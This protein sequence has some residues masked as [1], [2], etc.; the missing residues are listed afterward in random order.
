MDMKGEYRINASREAVWAGLND[1][2]VLRQSIP[3]CESL[4]KTSDTDFAAQVTAKVGP[5]KAK[6][7]GAVTLSD[8]N[9]PESYRIG[10]EGKGGAAGFAKGGAFVRLTPDGDGTLLSYEVNANVG[11]K[12]AQLGGRLIDSTAKKMADDFFRRF[13]E[14]VESEG[15]GAPAVPPAPSIEERPEAEAVKPPEPTPEPPAAEPAPEERPAE[16]PAYRPTRPA[17]PE[18]EEVRP[19]GLSPVTWIAGL[20]LIILVLVLVLS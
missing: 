3:G 12:L 15:A 5:V 20:I 14:I 9:P 7:N 1:P 4:E 10:G 8:L 16:T 19:A 18:R 2:D 11:G 6:F 17:E 13:G